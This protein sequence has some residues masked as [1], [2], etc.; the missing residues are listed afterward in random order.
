MLT[1]TPEQTTLLVWGWSVHIVADWFLQNHWMATHKTSLKHPA[2][3]VHSGIHGVLSLLVFPWPVALALFV[4]H[5]LIDLRTPLLWWGRVVGQ[6]T[7]EQMGSAYVPFAF[8]RDQAAHWVCLA[9]AA[10]WAGQ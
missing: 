10:Y 9:V 3:Y 7:P 8:L 2:A 5:L 4:A 6:S 1:F